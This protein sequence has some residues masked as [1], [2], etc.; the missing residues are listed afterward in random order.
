MSVLEVSWKDVQRDSIG[1]HHCAS[2][3]CL[4]YVDESK[5]DLFDGKLDWNT[6]ICSKYI[7]DEIFPIFCKDS[8]FVGFFLKKFIIFPF[9]SCL[10]FSFCVKIKIFFLNTFRLQGLCYCILNCPMM[11]SFTFPNLWFINN[12]KVLFLCNVKNIME[13]ATKLQ[14]LI[15]HN[16]PSTY[17]IFSNMAYFSYRD[18]LFYNNYYS[19][20]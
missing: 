9:V 13:P 18:M 4:L 7:K 19:T 14:M 6:V 15:G 17:Y 8:T 2:A 12:C 16:D 3:Y 11:K 20:T 10:I 5:P 1:G